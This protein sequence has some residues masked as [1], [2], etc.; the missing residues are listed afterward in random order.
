VRQEI[1]KEGSF[2]R[3]TVTNEGKRTR[4][5]VV[6]QHDD[7]RAL[8]VGEHN[9]TRAIT[10]SL[11]HVLGDALSE[12]SA[13]HH[14]TGLAALNKIA[15]HLGQARSPRTGQQQQLPPPMASSGLSLVVNTFEKP[16]RSHFVCPICRSKYQT[17]K[18][19][20]NNH[21]KETTTFFQSCP[22]VGRM[23]YF[24]N[25]VPRQPES[26]LEAEIW[27]HLVRNI[28]PAHQAAVSG[29][30]KETYEAFIQSFSQGGGN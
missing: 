3:K 6:D 21:T 29:G 11:A 28:E 18:T 27:N 1:Q 23:E 4:S 9:E 25:K 16:G 22:P 7:T 19:F 10:A 13:R 14:Q 17:D 5:V 24:L 12:S 2:I 15:E 8:V 26:W 20:K 30:K